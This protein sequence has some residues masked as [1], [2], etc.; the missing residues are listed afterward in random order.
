MQ[1]IIIKGARVH[2]LKNIDVRLPHNKLIVVTGLSGSGKSTLAFDTI[3]AEGQRRYVESLSAYARQF[4]GKI[5]KPDVDYITGIAPAIAVEQKV[6]TRNPRSTVGTS[7]EIYDYLRLLFARIGKT[8]SP[9]SG[10]Q[11]VAHSVDDVVEYILTLDEGCRLLICCDIELAEDQGVIERLTLL[12]K[13]GFRRLMVDGDVVEIE[14][15]IKGDVSKKWSVIVDRVQLAQK[16][17]KDQLARLLDSCGRAFSLGNGNCSIKVIG[18]SEPKFFSSKFEADGI[19]FERPTNH[20]F[21]FNNPIGACP[22]CEGVGK[23]DGIDENLVIP[24]KGKSIF[25]DAV[26]CWRGETMRWWKQQIIELGAKSGI[27]IHKPYYEFTREQKL[28]LWS[29]NEYFQGLD[30]F[31]EMLKEGR[32]K[33][34]YSVMLSRYSGK[35]VCYE[36]Q[37]GRLKKEAGYV[38]VSGKTITELVFMPIDKLLDFFTHISLDEHD[39]TI[40]ERIMTEIKNRLQ[41][42]LDVGLGYLNLDRMSATLSGGESQRINLA[43]MLGS[44][45]VGSLYILDEPSIGLH[46]RDTE[47]LIKVLKQLRDIGNTVIVVE[48]DIEIMKAADL[49][50]D[51]GPMA[52]AHGGEVVFKGTYDQLHTAKY[53]KT[54]DFLLGRDSINPP[55]RVRKWNNFIEIKG[56]RQNNLK[57]IDVKIPLGVITCITG[58][59]GSGKSSLVDDILYPAL[60]RELLEIGSFPGDFGSISGDLKKIKSIELI[61]QNPLGR[62]MRSNPVTYIKAYDEIRKLFS[63]LPKAKTFG[64]DPSSFSFNI[65]GGRCEECKGEGVIRVEM[66]FMADV[67]LVCDHCKGKR[68]KDNVLEVKYREKSISD[69]LDMPIEDAITFF[70][71]DVANSDGVREK[72][73]LCEKIVEK[74]KVL[75]DVGLGYVK[76]GQPI[77]TLSGGERQRVKLASFLLKESTADP[78][79]FIFDEPT[80]GLHFYDIKKLLKSL[81]SLVERGHTVVI[82]EHN[83]DVVKCADWVIDLGIE[84]GR[85]GGNLVFEGT[86]KDLS[87][88]DLGYTSKYL[89]LA[90]GV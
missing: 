65:A 72:K 14:E 57:N 62:T 42:L 76:L 56:A 25:D 74:L 16:D 77:S 5:E 21:S 83:M 87:N 40:A 55:E 75:D 86:P 49:I 46:P 63:E 33:I 67:E 70:G 2:N 12:L 68:F 50:V 41:Y 6:N 35:S 22:K 1:E 43:T 38:K 28:L 64:F 47:R 71:E 78:I 79:L 24:D 84:G 19:L 59:S 69:V 13:D 15:F 73:R 61:D 44:S 30:A 7:T 10:S 27:P 88:T 54:A 66:Q 20:L 34:Q 3:F 60:R 58:V 90:Y 4:L 32:Y 11:V 37:G 23:I 26:A 36:C 29:G 82:V 18:E 39:R 17:D 52:G 81:N 80:T 31:F 9:I 89:K 8:I 51:M 53:S 48:H 45:L 85:D